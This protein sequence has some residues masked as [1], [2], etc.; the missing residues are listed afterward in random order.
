MM[1]FIRLGKVMKRTI[2]KTHLVPS[3]EK[4][5]RGF[6]S[7]LIL[8]LLLGS[9][10]VAEVVTRGAD[11]A[12]NTLISKERY[13]TLSQNPQF[14]LTYNRYHRYEQDVFAAMLLSTYGDNKSKIYLLND[15]DRT[16]VISYGMKPSLDCILVTDFQSFCEEVYI[17]GHEQMGYIY[18]GKATLE[19]LVAVMF[20]KA[21]KPTLYNI[22]KLY[23]CVNHE[24]NK[25]YSNGGS[26]I[27]YH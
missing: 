16:I 17:S 19:K 15:F 1:G 5:L 4:F 26:E 2:L 20:G 7:F 11:F 12:P 10:F 14:F 9:G 21:E 18:L 22:S 27:Y 25:I 3:Q 6:C 23:H 13:G 24:S 8:I